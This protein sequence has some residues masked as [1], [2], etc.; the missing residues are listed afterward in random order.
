MKCLEMTNDSCRIHPT[1]RLQFSV[2]DTSLVEVS[3]MPQ[4]KS[5]YYQVIY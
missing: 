4:K 5:A 2:S 1:L 3:E